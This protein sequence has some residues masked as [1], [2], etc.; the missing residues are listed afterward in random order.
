MATSAG[1]TTDGKL[2][3]WGQNAYG[4]MG[5]AA[6]S[7]SP[8]MLFSDTTWSDISAIAAGFHAIKG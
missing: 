1:L 4:S 6:S 3:A 8:V 5:E 2:W 7:A